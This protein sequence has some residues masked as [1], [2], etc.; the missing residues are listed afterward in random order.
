MK[1]Y[2]IEIKFNNKNAA[3][4]RL[5]YNLDTSLTLSDVLEQL[6]TLEQ[7][8]INRNGDILSID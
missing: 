2:Q 8:R 5:Y 4:L 1:R 3:T 6:N 7:I